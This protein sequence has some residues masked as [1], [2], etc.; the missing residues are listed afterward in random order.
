[1]ENILF[2]KD[3]YDPLENK[4][5]KLVVTKDE[6]SKKMNQKIIGSIKQLIRHEVF[7]HVAQET[8]AY[9][10]WTMFETMYKAKKSWNK[11]FLMRRR[12]NLKLKGGTLVGKHMRMIY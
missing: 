10:L 8:S 12:V 7:H 3:L 1:M 2:Y 6:K 9:K 11:A 5:V 4:K